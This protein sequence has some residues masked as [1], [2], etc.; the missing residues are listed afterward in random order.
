MEGD[1]EASSAVPSSSSPSLASAHSAV[2]GL[3]RRMSPKLQSQTQS[4]A[5]L[6]TLLLHS[7]APPPYPHHPPHPPPRPSTRGLLPTSSSSFSSASSDVRGSSALRLLLSFVAVAACLALLSI[8]LDHLA[9]T[10]QPSTSALCTDHLS[11]T[12]AHTISAAAASTPAPTTHSDEGKGEIVK[13][14][15]PPPATAQ[16]SA[17]P[18]SSPAPPFYDSCLS[19]LSTPPLASILAAN[20]VRCSASDGRSGAVVDAKDERLASA[21]AAYEHRLRTTLSAN[22]LTFFDWQRP[23]QQQSSNA[24]G[25][26]DEAEPLILRMGALYASQSSASSPLNLTTSSV[27]N[28][29]YSISTWSNLCLS[30]GYPGEP[31][32]VALIGEDTAALQRL[33]D[34]ELLNPQQQQRHPFAWMPPRYCNDQARLTV[35]ARADDDWVWIAA[36]E[37]QAAVHQLEWDFNVGH[38]FHQQVLPMYTAITAGQ[39]FHRAQATLLLIDAGCADSASSLGVRHGAWKSINQFLARIAVEGVKDRVRLMRQSCEDGGR[40]VSAGVCFERLLLN[41]PA[42]QYLDR[43]QGDSS[44][45]SFRRFRALILSQLDLSPPPFPSSPHL[46]PLRVTIYSRLDS[47][48]RRIL[49]VDALV[50]ALSPHHIVRHIPDFGSRPAHEQLALYAHTDLL[51]APHGAHMTF[52]FLLPEQGVVAEV[53]AHSEGKFSWTVNFLAATRHRH[54]QQV[55]I[56]DFPGHTPLEQ[57]EK[58]LRHMDRD[59]H[60]NLTTLCTQLR[61]IHIPITYTC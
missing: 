53:F 3:A 50:A 23:E 19:L 42:D 61:S 4:Q 46:T 15:H 32:R 22:A 28:A 57:L 8:S 56:A 47:A 9:F 60:V 38:Q 24:A 17:T 21:I 36:K 54:L 44:F 45:E 29:D 20:G 41:S 6:Q 40:R 5:Q 52:A 16:P 25:A 49:N 34:E 30:L 12:A 14:P 35:Q 59:F 11:C 55:G 33:V 13:P 39:L 58:G 18:P 43:G 48:R 2:T 31:M 1:G 10:A 26:G 37:G 7:S 27:R 51:I